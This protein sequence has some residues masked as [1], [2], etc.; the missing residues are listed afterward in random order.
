MRANPADVWQATNF[1]K[2]HFTGVEASAA[3]EPAR[4]RPFSATFAALRGVTETPE[5]LESK[6]VF[7]YPVYSAVAQWSGALPGCLI[8]RTRI[9]VA[10]RLQRAPY[11]VWDASAGYAAGRVRP[12]LQLTNIAS[13]VYQDIPGVAMPS[14]GIVG[15]L[16]IVL[17][18]ARR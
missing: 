7:N 5:A 14:R 16:E 18:G 17:A 9:G 1:D 15:G 3:Y 12:F 2:L 4:A 8:A 11:A 10:H 13:T 6:Y